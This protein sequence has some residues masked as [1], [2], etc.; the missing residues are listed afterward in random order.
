MGKRCEKGKIKM[1]NNIKERRKALA[2]LSANVTKDVSGHNPTVSVDERILDAAIDASAMGQMERASELAARAISQLTPDRMHAIWRAREKEKARFRDEGPRP[3]FMYHCPMCTFTSEREHI[4]Q[5]H[6]D[7]HLEYHCELC[8]AF[9]THEWKLWQHTQENHI[10]SEDNDYYATKRCPFC[11]RWQHT[12]RRLE[13]HVRHLHLSV[14]SCAQCDF[15]C[16][17]PFNKVWHAERVH[18]PGFIPNPICQSGQC[19]FPTQH[20]QGTLRI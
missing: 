13:R 15:K 10:S 11:G 12:A 18:R 5:K 4:F 16:N 8:P 2:N 17:S 20:H 3:R 1:P 9:Y 7:N 6:V 14:V 19:P